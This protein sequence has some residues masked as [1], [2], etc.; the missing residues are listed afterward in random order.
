MK[1]DEITKDEFV[2]KLKDPRIKLLNKR[3]RIFRREAE[4]YGWKVD[5]TQDESGTFTLQ[6]SIPTN[7][8]SSLELSSMIWD[9]FKDDGF[10]E[11]MHIL[12]YFSG[13]EEVNDMFLISYGFD[14]E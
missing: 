11:K 8:Y 1:L 7:E 10:T 9:V 5:W 12:V 13:K 4:G 6:T 2:E 3:V 14:L